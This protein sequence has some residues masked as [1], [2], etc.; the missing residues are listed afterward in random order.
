MGGGGVSITAIWLS[1]IVAFYEFFI[2]MAK[3]PNIESE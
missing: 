3:W 1:V 2:P